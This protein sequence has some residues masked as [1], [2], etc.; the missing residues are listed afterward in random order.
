MR[1]WT[2]LK[3]KTR[4]IIGRRRTA[5]TIK[6]HPAC[7]LDHTVYVCTYL[8]QGNEERRKLELF[9]QDRRHQK[10]KEKFVQLFSRRKRCYFFSSWARLVTSLRK[11][12]PLPS[13]RSF[14]LLSYPLALAAAAAV[15]P[16]SIFVYIK[17]QL[18]DSDRRSQGRHQLGAVFFSRR[19]WTD[20]EFGGVGIDRT[21]TTM[22]SA[23]ATLPEFSIE[24]GPKQIKTYHY[25]LNW[26]WAKVFE[27]ITM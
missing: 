18:A 6:H 12:W 27:F 26:Y 23:A 16:H 19:P 1:A 7:W 24:A 4:N 25:F 5:A 10:R 13:T 11:L 8:S 22:E 14:L 20:L 3:T 15:S 17:Q 21:T 2:N 9:F